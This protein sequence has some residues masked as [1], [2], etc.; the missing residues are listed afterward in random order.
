MYFEHIFIIHVLSR[1]TKLIPFV[2]LSHFRLIP[3]SFVKQIDTFL[4]YVTDQAKV[5]RTNNVILTM[6]GDFTYQQAEM[7]FANM[8][9]LIRYLHFVKSLVSFHAKTCRY[10]AYMYIYE[11]YT[12]GKGRERSYNR[13]DIE[14]LVKIELVSKMHCG[15]WQVEQL[16]HYA[17]LQATFYKTNNVIF[18]MGEDFNYQHAEMWFTNLDRL[19]R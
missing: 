4:Q 1:I 18:T 8:D 5:Y 12:G 16:V 6:G 7:Y 11:E 9:K 13:N 3:I 17:H 19:I 2:A 10:H 14:C 15:H